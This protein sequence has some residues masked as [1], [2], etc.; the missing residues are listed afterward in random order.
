M[1][2]PGRVVLVSS[3]EYCRS[4]GVIMKATGG[5]G[6][7]FSTSQPSL[8]VL[9]LPGEAQDFTLR[10]PMS[11]G[12]LMT[13]CQPSSPVKHCIVTVAHSAVIAITRATLKADWDSL[14]FQHSRHGYN[15]NIDF[16]RRDRNHTIGTLL[17]TQMINGYWVLCRSYYE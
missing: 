2:T 15:K 16:I 6:S 11:G 7:R 12:V 4:L 3:A 14:A 13:M 5:S 17:V 1:L 10:T 8:T 9:L